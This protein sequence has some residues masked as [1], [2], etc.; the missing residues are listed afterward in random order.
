MDSLSKKEIA[1]LLLIDFSKAFDMIEHKILIR[2]LGHYGIRGIVLE[3]FK[4]YLD[5]RSQYVTVHGIDSS[6][7]PI[8]CSV[9]QG[10][11]LGPLLFVIYISTT[12]H[13]YLMQL[14]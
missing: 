3:W 5:K 14:D 13:V 2:K 9:P 12:F 11:I 1:M 8:N 6:T 10:S 7:R 4:S